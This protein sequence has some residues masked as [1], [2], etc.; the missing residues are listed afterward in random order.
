MRL[1][2]ARAS[3]V[4]L[5]ALGCAGCVGTPKNPTNVP[6]VETRVRQGV[7][8]GASRQ[9]IE[10]WLTSQHLEFGYGQ[11]KPD[12]HDSVIEDSGLDPA[13]IG[14][15]ITAAIPDTTRSIWVRVDI[16]I[17]FYLDHDGRLLKHRVEWIGTGP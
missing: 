6:A 17:Y 8:A 4:L 5:A 9:E 7:A 1:L 14:A 13:S 2:A 12:D 3:A 16:Y 15:L 11:V 10:A